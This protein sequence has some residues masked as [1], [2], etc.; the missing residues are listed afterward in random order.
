MDIDKLDSRFDELVSY[1]GYRNNALDFLE[2]RLGFNVNNF[3]RQ[4]ERDTNVPEEVV[5]TL[6]DLVVEEQERVDKLKEIEKEYS[7]PYG[8]V[9]ET[10]EIDDDTIDL[11]KKFMGYRTTEVI[12]DNLDTRKNLVSSWIHRKQKNMHY[13]SLAIICQYMDKDIDIDIERRYDVGLF[14]KL[15]YNYCHNSDDSLSQ[16]IDELKSVANI[17][18]RSIR[19]LINA[20]RDES[21]N[22]KTVSEELWDWIVE[23]NKDLGFEDITD[24]KLVHYSNHGNSF[25]EIANFRKKYYFC[26]VYEN[27]N[28]KEILLEIL[29]RSE[30]KKLTLDD[31]KLGRVTEKEMNALDDMV[32]DVIEK[33][34]VSLLKSSHTYLTIR[35]AEKKSG[36]SN[37]F[38]RKIVKKGILKTNFD[39]DFNEVLPSCELYRLNR[40]KEAEKTYIN[41]IIELIKEKPYY[42]KKDLVRLRLGISLA[43]DNEQVSSE[44]LIN[45]LN[46]K[47]YPCFDSYVDLVD[48]NHVKK[49]Y[50]RY[51]E[52]FEIKAALINYRKGEGTILCIK[53][54]KGTRFCD[55][56]RFLSKPF[57]DYHYGIAGEH[58]GSVKKDKD[59]LYITRA[60]LDNYFTKKIIKRFKKFNV[61]VQKVKLSKKYDAHNQSIDWIKA[62]M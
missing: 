21:A 4:T 58:A 24:I 46:T 39:E 49:R 11:L 16:N 31:V 54:K 42:S 56:R 61:D 48:D 30:N 43:N 36:F 52:Q 1:I 29:D 26:S 40:I 27:K 38:I 12:V 55:L 50:S 14:N 33:N 51:L 13:K 17:S 18:D 62:N 23:K 2:N 10:F 57:I 60:V 19:K 20:H 6:D 32:H 25:Q 35:K 59:N 45:Y 44:R 5:K 41:N 22:Y 3:F 37:S 34:K 7:M 15:F 28:Y 9:S 8:C 47:Y 53:Y